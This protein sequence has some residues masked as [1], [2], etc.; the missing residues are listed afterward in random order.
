[1]QLFA[2][3]ATITTSTIMLFLLGSST[4][5]RAFTPSTGASF[6]RRSSTNSASTPLQAVAKSDSYS[7]TLLPGDGIGPEITEATRGVLEAVADR[8]GFSMDLK[9]AL[10]GGAAID[11]VQDPFPQE[12][13]DQCRASDSVLLACI[14]GYKVRYHVLDFVVLSL[15][16]CC[17]D[18]LVGH[19]RGTNCRGC[20]R[21]IFACVYSF[22][23]SLGH[24]STDTVQDTI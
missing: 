7:V 2:G 23:H 1:M 20:R 9:E 3:T 15:V 4:M 18:C 13:L 16:D 11:A 24:V 5:T 17:H 21:P 8:F 12:S 6:V 22:I 14:G 10:I 19:F